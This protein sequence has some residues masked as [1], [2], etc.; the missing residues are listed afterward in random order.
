MARPKKTDAEKLAELLGIEAPKGNPYETAEDISRE[1]EA[2]IIYAESPQSFIR[3]NCK[4]CGRTFAHTRGAIAYCSN[5]CRARG[6]EQIGIKWD[7]TRPTEVRWGLYDGGEPLIVPAEA[8]KLVDQASD[9][10][11]NLK[12]PV[13]NHMRDQPEHGSWCWGDEPVPDDIELVAYA[14]K[15][16]P[17]P[18]PEPEPKSEIEPDPM[19]AALDILAELG[20]D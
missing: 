2:T 14:P 17:E 6:L 7:W 20:L 4:I 19:D 3:K 11:D 12:C 9:S 1:A 13:Y 18:E 8:V 10:Q 15:P 5:L 16:E